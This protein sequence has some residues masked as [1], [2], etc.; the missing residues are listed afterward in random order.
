MTVSLGTAQVLTSPNPFCLVG[1]T[2][3]DGTTNL[4]ALSWWT[5]LSNHPATVCVCVNRGAATNHNIKERKEFSICVVD[6]SLADVAMKCAVSGY[7]VNKV[8]EYGIAMVKA[9]EI[10]VDLVEKS[11]VAMECRLMQCVELSDHDLFIGEVVALH[12]NDAYQPLY[13]A[14][15]YKKLQGV[16][17]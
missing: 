6:T 4:M 16:Q 2:M 15:G 7:K 9:N 11:V 12:T 1:S 14:E 8:Q 13:A 17:L 10:S 3:D 5:Y